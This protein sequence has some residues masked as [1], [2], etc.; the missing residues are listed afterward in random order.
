MIDKE[1][2]GCYFGR[3][4]CTAVCIHEKIVRMIRWEI[5]DSERIDNI[6]AVK[7]TGESVFDNHQ[8]CGISG[9]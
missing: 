1:N 5:Q 2:R 3:R 4:N 7:T 9:A 8:C 6:F